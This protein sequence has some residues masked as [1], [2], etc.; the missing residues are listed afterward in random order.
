MRLI[1][2]MII[3]AFVTAIIHSALPPFLSKK[4]TFQ[5]ST[6]LYI[7]VTVVFTILAR[8]IR[9]CSRFDRYTMYQNE[10][11]RPSRA[12]ERVMLEDTRNR[13]S[14]SRPPNDK[15]SWSVS[16]PIGSFSVTE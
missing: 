15:V 14:S 16:G 6:W 10:G 3:A 13:T 12:L 1:I 9:D 2:G 5:H 8:T 4:M 7:I 11:L